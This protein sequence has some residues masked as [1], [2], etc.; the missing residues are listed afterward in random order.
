M[1]RSGGNSVKFL[2]TWGSGVAG[3]QLPKR[4]IKE[5]ALR[6]ESAGFPCS[7]STPNHKAAAFGCMQ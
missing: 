2:I 4:G 5:R 6:G 3:G 1:K 7:H